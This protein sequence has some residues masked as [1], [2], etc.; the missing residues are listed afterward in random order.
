M[1][2]VVLSTKNLKFQ[3]FLSY[4]NVEILGEKCTF[5]MGESGCGK[6]TLFKLMN[7]T[8]SYSQGS[9]EY[10]GRNIEKWDTIDLRREILLTSQEIYLFEGTIED[11][12]RKYYEFREKECISKVQMEDYLSICCAPFP[13]ESRCEVL[14]GGER[15]RV[16]TAICISFLPKVLLMDEPTA[17][18]DEVT[19]HKF[20]KQIKDFCQEQHITL[21][22]ICHNSHLVDEYADY[23]V[24]LDARYGEG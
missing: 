22:V 21:V 7:A 1:D 19:S 2:Q 12:Y 5:L 10:E 6:S 3:D 11:N 23:V 16:F 13:L 24:A 4:P 17:A 14:S 18:L 8:L 20:F 9:I 15:Q